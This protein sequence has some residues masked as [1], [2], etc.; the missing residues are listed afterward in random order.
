MKN[1]AMISAAALV[2]GLA[3][4]AAF[5]DLESS[6]SSHVWVDVDPNI[7]VL[8]TGMVDLGSVQTGDFAGTIIFRVDAN[9]E[10]VFLTCGASPLY[11]GDDPLG[12]EVT[13]IDVNLSE[14]C[15]VV[16]ANGKRMEGLPNNLSFGTE[17]EIIDGFPLT[18]TEQGHFE[19]SQNGHFSQEVTVSVTWMQPDPEKPQGE[20][21][22]VVALW[23]AIL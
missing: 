4:S 3:A 8:S 17:Q 11:K 19:S 5:A 23:G 15:D 9:N 21:S 13:P 18:K 22:G 10:D 2:S 12:T 1:L 16:P 20:Y 14:G 7:G 6:A